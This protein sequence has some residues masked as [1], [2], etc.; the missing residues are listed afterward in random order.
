MAIDRAVQTFRG[1][2]PAMIHPADT[3]EDGVQRPQ[4][5]LQKWFPGGGGQQMIDPA[6]QLVERFD[7][8]RGPV[9]A[10]CAGKMQE[11]GAVGRARSFCCQPHHKSLHIPAQP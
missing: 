6:V 2:D 5:V 7:R 1:A 10:Q 9:A 8:Q 4:C 11:L 3:P